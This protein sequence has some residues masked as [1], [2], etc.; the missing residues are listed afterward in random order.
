M[1]SPSDTIHILSR[2]RTK[3]W[4]FDWRPSIRYTVYQYLPLVILSIVIAY[5]DSMDKE[6]LLFIWCLGILILRLQHLTGPVHSFKQMYSQHWEV[7]RGKIRRVSRTP[8]NEWGSQPFSLV[9]QINNLISWCSL[10]DPDSNCP[11]DPL[12][13]LLIWIYIHHHLHSEKFKPPWKSQDRSHHSL[14]LAQR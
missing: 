9:Q 8:S 2:E 12:L 14:E 11:S 10:P 5:F 7:S 4:L 3:W 1:R 13:Q 6:M